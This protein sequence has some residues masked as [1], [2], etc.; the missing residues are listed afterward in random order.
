MT[1]HSNSSQ[2]RLPEITFSCIPPSLSHIL[3]RM[4]LSVRQNY[5][6]ECEAAVNKQVHG[7]LCAMYTYMAMVSRDKV[8]QPKRICT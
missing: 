8:M 3:F 2:G 1:M 6:D 7:E 5:S 4:A